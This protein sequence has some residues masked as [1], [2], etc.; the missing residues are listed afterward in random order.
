MQIGV[1]DADFPDTER[2]KVRDTTGYVQ[3]S[4]N[5]YL[6]MALYKAMNT[7]KRNEM[8]TLFIDSNNSCLKEGPQKTQHPLS[9]ILVEHADRSGVLMPMRSLK[10]GSK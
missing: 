7:E 2:V 8:V 5:P 3:V 4:I 1:H 9:A 10:K 6:L